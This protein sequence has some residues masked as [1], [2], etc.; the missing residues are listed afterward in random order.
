MPFAFAP[1]GVLG[2]GRLLARPYASAAASPSLLRPMADEWGT[3]APIVAGAARL[4]GTAVPGTA[5]QDLNA[6]NDGTTL[7]IHSSGRP[8]S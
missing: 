1:A 5:Q 8:L 6:Q 3:G 7:G 4:R 2:S